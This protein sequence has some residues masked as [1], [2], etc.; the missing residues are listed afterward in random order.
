M[1]LKYHSWRS[2]LLVAFT[3]CNLLKPSYA[4]GSRPSTVDCSLLHV[5]DKWGGRLPRSLHCAP[6]HSTPSPWT[7]HLDPTPN[8]GEPRAQ[9]AGVTLARDCQ[10]YR[11][12]CLNSG[13][14]LSFQDVRTN[15]N[16]KKKLN[17]PCW[18]Q[19]ERFPS[20]LFLSE[21]FNVSTF[22]ISLKCTFVET[23]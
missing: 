3:L 6:P 14:T 10:N 13:P 4:V 2:P 16:L 1:T 21:Y 8:P 7:P 17:P 20:P 15:A 11:E 22:S 19:G 12:G 18:K 23:K 9:N 5:W